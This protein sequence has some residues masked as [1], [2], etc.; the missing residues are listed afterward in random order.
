[1][2]TYFQSYKK[3]HPYEPTY[4]FSPPT[5]VFNFCFPPGL[6]KVSVTQVFL[7]K[8]IT[9]SVTTVLHP[10]RHPALGNWPKILLSFCCK[11]LP[12]FMLYSSRFLICKVQVFL[13]DTGRSVDVEGCCLLFSLQNAHCK[14]TTRA[15]ELEGEWRLLLHHLAPLN[16]TR[17]CAT[18]VAVFCLKQSKI[19]RK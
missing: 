8:K 6:S 7:W 18:T 17:P 13:H 14:P 16:Q 11:S 5:S 19:W 4:H 2:V 12:F 9:L 1:M 15:G 3:V 10:L